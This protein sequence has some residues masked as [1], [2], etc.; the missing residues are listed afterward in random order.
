MN[1]IE[2]STS[3]KKHFWVFPFIVVLL[4]AGLVLFFRF[5][6]TSQKQEFV[7]RISPTYLDITTA[8]FNT[9]L[10]KQPKTPKKLF[11]YKVTEGQNLLEKFNDFKSILRLD[12]NESDFNH[13]TLGSGKR[14]FTSNGSLLQVFKNY[15][16]FIRPNT[17]RQESQTYKPTPEL[18]QKAKEFFEELSLKTPPDYIVSYTK[19]AGEFSYED[20]SE[21]KSANINL[22][23]IE[24][25]SDQPVY[26]PNNKTRASF[27]KPGNLIIATYSGHDTQELSQYPVISLTKALQKLTVETKPVK[28]FGEGELYFKTKQ[29]TQKVDLTNAYLAYF[30][31]EKNPRVLTPVWVFEGETTI[32][33]KKLYLEY[34]LDAIEP[35]FLETTSQP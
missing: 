25:L 20:K 12:G 21:E 5:Y 1:L 23:L 29:R 28:V 3:L 11:V 14:V 13:T 17:E 33:Q 31:D 27:D 7:P 4:I 32:S 22:T 2:L 6:Q 8:T 30:L 34:A 26:S 16:Y 19:Y 10:L 15:M 9:S 24:K 35:N 18:S